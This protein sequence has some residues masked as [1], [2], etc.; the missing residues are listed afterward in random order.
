[1]LYF[2]D[3]FAAIIS[4]Y[5]HDHYICCQ[6]VIMNFVSS[7]H[8]IAVPFFSM[9]YFTIKLWIYESSSVNPFIIIHYALNSLD[10][11]YLSTNHL[12]YESIVDM[13]IFFW[14]IRDSAHFLFCTFGY[15]FCYWCSF[16]YNSRNLCVFCAKG[17]TPAVSIWH[18]VKILSIYRENAL[19][20]IISSTL[21]MVPFGF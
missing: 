15:V 20:V 8:Y 6:N 10:M 16:P 12:V 9:K 4:S 5:F 11:Y 13:N 1:M 17:L 7:G 21:A 2:V 19:S 14:V 3:S 18:L